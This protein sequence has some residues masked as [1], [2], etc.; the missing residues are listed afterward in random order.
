MILRRLFLLGAIGLLTLTGCGGDD[1]SNTDQSLS[2]VYLVRHAEKAKGDNPK[3]TDAG[4]VRA[5]ALSALLSGQDVTHIHSTKYRRTLETAQPLAGATGL[6][7]ELYDPGDLSG[8]ADKVR[9]QPGVHVIVGHSNTT[10]QLA[11]LI[12]NE[13]MEEMPETEYNRLTKIILD[14]TGKTVVTSVTTYG[15]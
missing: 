1:S 4:I 5:Q 6:K 12:A 9:R 8:M 14:E 13:P 15:R 2:E 7:V 3:L 11:A 10:P